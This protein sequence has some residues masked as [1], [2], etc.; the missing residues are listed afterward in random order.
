MEIVAAIDA[1]GNV[2]NTIAWDGTGGMDFSNAYPGC[3]FLLIPP[4]PPVP[5][6]AGGTYDEQTQEFTPAVV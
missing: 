1:D 3:T 4:V 6:E 2:V 5:V